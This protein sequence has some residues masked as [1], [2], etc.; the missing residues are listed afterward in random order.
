LYFAILL[1]KADPASYITVYE[2]NR[3]NDT[4]GFGV[5][6]SDATLDRLAEADRTTH[7]EMTQAF[8]HWD[9]IEIHHRGTTTSSTG[10]GFSGL[11]RQ[12]LLT[13]LGRRCEELGIE[14]RFESEIGGFDAVKD[15]DLILGADGFNSVVRDWFR[16]QFKPNIDWRSNRFVWLGT[17]RS[18]PAFTFYF[19]ESPY[20][21][22]RVHAYQYEAGHSTFIVEARKETW[23]AAGM[24]RA[25]EEDT[26]AFCEELFAEEL[27]GHPLLANRSIW[28]Q[29][30]TIRNANWHH[31]NVVLI[32][33]AAHTA[34]FSVGS[35]TKLAMEDAI[36]LVEAL[37]RTADVPG[38]LTMYE[39]TRRPEVESLQRAAQVS[40]EWFEATERYRAL[41][42]V[43]FA[44]NL[45]TRSLRITH[46][47]LRIRDPEFVASVDQTF[48]QQAI[49]Q[50][51]VAV[52]TS[53]APP[54]LFT[55]FRL[56]D[57][58]LPNRI[59]VSPM[60]Q[61]SAED[62]TPGE[63]HL[64][65][66]GSRAVGGAGL[67]M[68]EMTDV[69]REGRI[70]P[71][72]AGMYLPEHLD[73]WRRIVHFVH[74]HSPAKIGIQLGH[75]GRKGATKVP[76]EG[77]DQPLE[78]GAWPVLAPSPVP[79]T[80]SHQVPRAMDR[81]DMTQ[82]RDDFVRATRMA[83]EAGFDLLELHFAHGYLLSSFIS[84][85][86]NQ[87]QDAYGGSLDN[88]LRFPLE[89]FDAVR[90]AWPASKPISVRISAVDWAP[91]GMEPPDAVEVARRLK[92]HNCDIIDVSA[93]QTVAHAK[94]VY[95]R[96]FQ[97]PFSDRIRH[98]ASIPTMAVGNI[99]S[100]MDVNSILAAGRADL[101]VMARAH[102]WDP[103]WT[104]HA[105]H[106]LGYPMPWTN[107][108]AVL[109]GYTPRF[110]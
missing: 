71:G 35:G 5:V 10:H 41:D 37:Q 90:E 33:D 34:H 56:R 59:V 77:M 93:G 16:D 7:D 19:K 73:A 54:P 66:L 28:R 60:C 103:Y 8:A 18:F 61:Y 79:Y 40:L 69:S 57:L 14:L 67:V 25:T 80:P 75:A 100:V 21:L 81:A 63:W 53:P 11:S 52:P 95:G 26:V 6:F 68:T 23:R 72:C 45:L 15:A 27:E 42:P 108:Y 97:T 46:E 13:I 70:S 24:E 49:A 3:L 12:R 31:G 107:P 89:V 51:R 22:W 2:R 96:Q 36:A 84:P 88:R 39:R 9:D 85:L 74:R 104:H 32:G 30:P 4:F 65:H 86:T 98:E 44:F 43:L 78:H 17:T 29:F 92:V 105:A 55:P 62:G 48:A 87:R 99:S 101:C 83:E 47:N 106:A 102:L 76:W 91:G 58:V 1:R 109:D 110:S 82:V 64:V 50:S 20:G 38:A 94:P